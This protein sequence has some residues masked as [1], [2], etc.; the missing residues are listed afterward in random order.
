M[1]YEKIF[2][3]LLA[4]AGGAFMGSGYVN[5]DLGNLI[6]GTAIW[7]AAGVKSWP[8]YMTRNPV[9]G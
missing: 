8:L 7:I 2:C 9:D 6:G 3:S 5:G 4:C 1:I